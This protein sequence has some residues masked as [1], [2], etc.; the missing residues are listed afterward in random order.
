M[1]NPASMAHLSPHQITESQ[2]TPL[3]HDVEST[4]PAMMLKKGRAERCAHGGLD[5]RRPINR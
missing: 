5:A 3:I 2:N 4:E 1:V